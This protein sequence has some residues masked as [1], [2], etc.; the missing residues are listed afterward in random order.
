MRVYVIMEA[1]DSPLG[2]LLDEAS[3]VDAAHRWDGDHCLYVQEWET[4]DRENCG[5]LLRE[6]TV[7]GGWR[8]EMRGRCDRA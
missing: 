4:G 2:V 7:D 8:N 1:Y 3:A 5:V 6:Y